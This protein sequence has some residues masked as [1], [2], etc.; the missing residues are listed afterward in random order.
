MKRLTLLGKLCGG[1][2]SI[3]LPTLAQIPSPSDIESALAQAEKQLQ[4]LDLKSLDLKIPAAA[5]AQAE[6][7]MAQLQVQPFPQPRPI[8]D[9]DRG[10][11]R[12]RSGDAGYDAGIRALDEHKYD[13]AIQDFD[14]VITAKSARADGALYWK[15]YSLNR[16]GRRDE[17]VAVIAAIRRDYP[18]SRWLNDAQALEVEAK[19][20]SGK[21]VSPADESNEEIKLIAINGLMQADPDRAV[22]LLEDVLKSSA[23]PKVKDRAMFV[24]TQSRS[25]RA[26]QIL[27][28]YAKGSTNPDLQIRA[29]RYMGMAGAQNADQLSSI[30]STSTDAEVKSA[31]LRALLTEGASTKLLDLV[32]NEKDPK[33]RVEIVRY[34]YSGGTPLGT[35][36]AL[37]ASETDPEVKKEIVRGLLS[38]GDA[39][40]LVDLA[41]KET[42]PTMKKNIVQYLSTMR[43]NKDA[44]DY[45]LELLK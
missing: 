44:T 2:L 25:P 10:K 36:T 16:L 32:R 45:M 38:R 39:K 20:N 1:L 40:D 31:I 7:A 22:P 17:A 5:M 27:S 8:V 21:P 14:K 30:Y 9:F 12:T 23:S 35:L 19:Q 11:G 34:S 26:Q 6:A 3:A 33:L 18:N 37:Y 15:A 28:N 24:L 43:N 4:S 29:I 42:D 41:R 13:Q